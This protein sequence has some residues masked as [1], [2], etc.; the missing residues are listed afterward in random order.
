MIV[1][2]LQLVQASICRNEQDSGRGDSDT[3][4]GLMEE[5]EWCAIMCHAQSDVARIQSV[6]IRTG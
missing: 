2:L 6:S 5:C 1:D 3:G 4:S